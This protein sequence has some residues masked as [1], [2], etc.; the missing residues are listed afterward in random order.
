[1]KLILKRIYIPSLYRV[2]LRWGADFE[3]NTDPTTFSR[4]HLRATLAVS[5]GAARPSPVRI[6]VTVE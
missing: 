5:A 4:G 2:L 6:K 3:Y 1:M